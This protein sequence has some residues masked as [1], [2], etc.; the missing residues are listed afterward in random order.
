LHPYRIP[1]RPVT[2]ADSATEACL[3]AR[4]RPAGRRRSGGRR[5][6][7]TPCRRPA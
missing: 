3:P 5:A 7:R 1:Y 6:C 2:A 4:R